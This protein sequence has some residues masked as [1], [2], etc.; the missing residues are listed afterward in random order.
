[1]LIQK[2]PLLIAEE[3]IT[4]ATNYV[5]GII[6]GVPIPFP[7]KNP[8]ACDGHGITCPMAPGKE[9]T[10]KTSLEVKTEY[11]QVKMDIVLVIAITKC[12]RESSNF[13]MLYKDT[14]MRSVY[15]G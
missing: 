12:Q 11:P 1:M 5:K 15:Y 3:N 9:Y 7:L 14:S 4:K 6:G 13:E 10:F 8:N 2:S